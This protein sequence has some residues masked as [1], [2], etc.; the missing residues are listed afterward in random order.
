MEEQ[1]EALVERPTS[2]GVS[3]HQS[4]RM[5]C[6]GLSKIIVLWSYMILL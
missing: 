4:F 2:P 3:F 6:H 1:E 5:D